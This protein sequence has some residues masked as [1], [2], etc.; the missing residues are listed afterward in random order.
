MKVT[1]IRHTTRPENMLITAAAVCVGREPVGSAGYK[2]ALASGH[3][4]LLE[5]L[6]YT[7]KV[8]GLSRAALAQLTRH[9]HATFSVESQRYVSYKNGIDYVK[10]EGMGLDYDEMMITMSD[11]YT[12]MLGEGKPAEDARFVLPNACTTN[13]IMTMNARALKNFFALRCCKRAQWEI[14]ELADKMLALV[15]PLIPGVFGEKA[16]FCDQ[17]GYCR[18]SKSCGRAPTLKGLLAGQLNALRDAA[19]ADADAHG[20]WEDEKAQDAFKQ[21]LWAAERVS[22][23]VNELLQAASADNAANYAEELADVI[24]TALSTAGLLGLD[25]QKAVKDKM[26][27]NKTRP[28]QHKEAL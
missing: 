4:S 7:F 20:L 2:N 19:Y 21:R 14:R 8:E 27:F 28:Y 23:E 16:A 15:Q 6:V 26:A 10:P 5:H 17:N 25:I 24:I 12:E 9:R 3:D 11:W 18:E 22:D 1:L 13:L